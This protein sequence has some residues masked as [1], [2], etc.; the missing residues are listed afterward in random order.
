MNRRIL[1]QVDERPNVLCKHA[2]LL[3]IYLNP[4]IEHANLKLRIYSVDSLCQMLG[5]SR[6]Y[7]NQRL[8]FSDGYTVTFYQL[9]DRR[10]KYPFK[11]FIYC[12]GKKK[13]FVS[14]TDN[15]EEIDKDEVLPYVQW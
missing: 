8:C 2:D 9:C 7:I 1:Y 5:C 10:H 12:I 13:F 15:H 14:L 3:K 6:T 11:F 4:E